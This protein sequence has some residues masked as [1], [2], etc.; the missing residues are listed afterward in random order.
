MAANTPKAPDGKICIA[1]I[2]A[3]H[4]VNG[5]VRVKLF[6]DDP[7]S[8]TIY[9]PLENA[10]GSRRFSIKYAKPSKGVYICRIKGLMDRNEAEMMNGTKLYV[11]R[12]CLPEPEEDAFYYCD[13]IG[14]EARLEDGNVL[15][16][17]VGVHDFG[18]GDLLDIVPLRGPSLFIPFTK[19]AVPEVNLGAG[20]VVVVPPLG[21]LDKPDPE[22]KAKEGLAADF[23][24]YPEFIEAL[25]TLKPDGSDGADG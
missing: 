24:L 15:G 19:E 7:A 12:S 9:G 8:L 4:G 23:S 25:D 17:I 20:Y 5:E 18:A 2:G 1:Q 3:A 22:D 11:D 14:C 21:L 13:L 10:D 6:S 16:A